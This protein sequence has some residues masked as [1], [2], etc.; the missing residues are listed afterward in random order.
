MPWVRFPHGVSFLQSVCMRQGT[1]GIT[2]RMPGPSHSTVLEATMTPSLLLPRPF[3]LFVPGDNSH[4][5]SATPQQG[6]RV[7]LGRV[8]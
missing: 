1:A 8:E 6:V 2:S 4:D 3:L 7:F 5:H